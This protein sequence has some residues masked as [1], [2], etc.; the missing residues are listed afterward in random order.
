MKKVFLYYFAMTGC[1]LHAQ[2]YRVS[3]IPDSLKDDA[4][5]V[6]RIDNTDI[7][8][9]GN[10]K[11][12]I[13][14]KWAYTILNEAGEHFSVY[15]NDYDQF[16]SLNDIT[17]KMYDANGKLIKTIHKKD[18]SD[19]SVNDGESLVNDARLKVFAFYNKVYPY[20]VEFEDEIILKGIFS[21]PGWHPVNAEKLAIM[22]S[23]FSV[24]TPRGY[25]LRYKQF[26]Y[27]GIPLIDSNEKRIVYQWKLSGKKAIRE[28]IYQPDW[29]EITPNV[30]LAPT[31][32][33]IAGYKGNMENWKNFGLFLTELI[34]NRQVLPDN[35][36]QE[37]HKLTDGLKNEEKIKVLY[38][39]L[40]DNTRY[41]GI[42]LGIGGWQP[43]DAVYVSKYKYG[44]CK[45][46]SNFMVSLLKEAGVKANYVTIYND[47]SFK[48]AYDDFPMNLFNHVIA[49]VPSQK[50]TIWL[51]CTN[52]TVSPGFLGESSSNRNALLIDE[53]G[54]HL[55][56]TPVYEKNDNQKIRKIEAGVD[57]GGNLEANIHTFFSGIE[58][59]SIHGL[60]YHFNKEEQEKYLNKVINLPTYKVEKVSFKETRDRIPAMDEFIMLNSSNY[61]AVTGKRLF[62]QPDIINVEQKLPSDRPRQFDVLIPYAY[63]EVD[64]ISIIIPKNYGIE[65]L[66]KNVSVSNKFGS[67]STSY[68]VT[69][70][71]IQLIRVQVHNAIHL[72]AEEYDALVKFYDI[73]YKTDRAKIVFI[74]NDN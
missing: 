11:A 67:Y 36:K 72:S 17:G 51:E 56:K 38:K 31:N 1:L 35:L 47:D 12:V 57:A 63:N 68:S 61:A 20:T 5:V 32:F 62:V 42:Q 43:F 15:H 45:A 54:G 44:D 39:Y 8:I 73:M 3:L 48:G 23:H 41:I 52:Q 24:E 34:K 7:T 4:N 59:E 9:K 22:E 40:Q 46:L 37:V 71:S 69:G 60:Y 26:C 55:V 49:C 2:D 16:Q 14:H 13:I 70:N 19:I 66:P 50:D 58:Q 33:E 10:E 53:D 27:N 65:T 28:E 25:L 30:L 18:I 6:K 29:T 21:L 64:S 74:K